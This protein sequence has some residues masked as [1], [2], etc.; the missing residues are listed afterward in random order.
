MSQCRDTGTP[1]ILGGSAPSPFSHVAKSSVPGE[2]RQ[3]HELREREI[4]AFGDRQRRGE[5]LGAIA[6]QAE[7]ERAEHVDAV[8]AELAQA[9]DQRVTSLVETLVDVLQA[10]RRD[11][12]DTDERA[13]DV[14]FPH[15]VEE[16]G[17]LGRFH[18]DLREEHGV[19]WK[20]RQRRHELEPF[21]ADTA[22]P[23]E[24]ARILA[25][26]RHAQVLERHRIEVVVGEGDEAE[27]AP[28]QID[29]LFDNALDVRC[30][31]FC[32]SVRHT[33]QNEQCF[34]QPR[35]VCTEAHM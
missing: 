30:R 8:R 7:D 20:L 23:I 26:R 9:G 15:R 25:P 16:L 19:A 14:R 13:L 10:F 11:G 35:T 34:G 31:G 28:A 1:S 2:R 6:R 21:G 4:R 12:F 29:D 32:P 27:A 5:R 18:G 3:H 17:I 33:E 22:Q 24:L